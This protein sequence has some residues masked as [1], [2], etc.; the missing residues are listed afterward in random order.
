MCAWCSGSG[1]V[2]WLRSCRWCREDEAGAPAACRSSWPSRPP[3]F[4]LPSLQR[5]CVIR[6]VYDAKT[7]EIGPGIYRFKAE[8]AFSGD[9]IAGGLSGVDG[10]G[11]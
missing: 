7:E 6:S 10:A 2:G 9:Q 5:D 3:A 4:R 1:G 11:A 8:I